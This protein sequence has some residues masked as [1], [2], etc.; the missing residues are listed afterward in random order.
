FDMGRGWTEIETLFAHQWDDGMVPHMVFHEAAP[1]YFPGPEVWGTGRPTPTSGITQPPIAGFAVHQMWQRSG[2][3][4]R[5]R[6]LLPKLDAYHAWFYRTRDP[7]GTGLVAVIH[8]WESRDNTVDWDEGFE[9]VPTDGVTPYMRNDT[10][11]ADPSTRPT[12]AHYDRYLWLV[13]HFR[14]LGWDSSKTHDA[15]PFQIVDPG[16]N[17]ILI[18]S[19]LETAALAEALGE[20][21]I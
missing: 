9:R 2:D 13:Q 16:F 20:G 3:D 10:K 5:A 18:R 12:K 4:A 15:S 6:A 7:Q 8:P 14:G 19:C 21:E 11:H 1:T 17:A